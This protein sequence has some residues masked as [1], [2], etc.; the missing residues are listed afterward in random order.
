[1]LEGEVPNPAKLP[2]G[3]PFH[4]R[5]RYAKPLCAEQTPDWRE[6]EPGHYVACHYAQDLQLG[7]MRG[8]DK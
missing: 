8:Y 3:C 7:G 4:P 1:M 2:S 6:L 5:C